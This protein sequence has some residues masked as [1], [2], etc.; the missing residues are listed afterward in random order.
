MTLMAGVWG[1]I[2]GGRWL[3]SSLGH[4]RA[5]FVAFLAAT[6]VVL[7]ARRRQDEIARSRRARHWAV[8]GLAGLSGWCCHTALTTLIAAV[9]L[10]LG[11][12]PRLRASGPPPG[13]LMLF[14][15]LLLAPIF[16]ELLY[17]ECLLPSLASR[18]GRPA[19]LLVSSACFALPHVE[20]WAVL[21]AFIVG[22]VLGALML[23][24]PDAG[25]CIAAHAGLN[26]AGLLAARASAPLPAGWGLV[27]VQ[28][29]VG[30]L[31]IAAA[32]AL[33]RRGQQRGP[34]ARKGSC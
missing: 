5:T 32:I 27:G 14:S 17:R 15:V 33:A 31:A 18:C 3:V 1:L 29:A 22:L 9:G 20:A 4:E 28:L 7:A 2:A 24:E 12:A 16:E 34:A 30:L 8:L 25:L 11:L 10:A 13:L 21:G 23:A 6:V 19:A 26:L